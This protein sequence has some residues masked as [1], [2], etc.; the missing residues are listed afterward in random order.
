LNLSIVCR[1]GIVSASPL[2]SHG[3]GWLGGQLVAPAGQAD[4][5]LTD[6]IA[7]GNVPSMQQFFCFV[8]R[9]ITSILAAQ[10]GVHLSSGYRVS[11]RCSKQFVCIA[12]RRRSPAGR[13]KKDGDQFRL[14]PV[15][16]QPFDLAIQILNLLNWG[17][18]GALPFAG[19]LDI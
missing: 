8:D 4:L 5:G 19:C 11:N 2:G 12:R 1:N 18:G 14:V 17:G 13:W 6:L 3:H 7:M 10:D 15:F 16:Q 9:D